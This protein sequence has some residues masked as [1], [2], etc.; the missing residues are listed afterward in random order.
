MYT[1]RRSY[2]KIPLTFLQNWKIHFSKIIARHTHAAIY[3]KSVINT[4]PAT[5]DHVTHQ[6]TSKMIVFDTA[7]LYESQ[8]DGIHRNRVMK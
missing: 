4:E 6:I 7:R 8:K 2:W 1:Y 3:D 5:V